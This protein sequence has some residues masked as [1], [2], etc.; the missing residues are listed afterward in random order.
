MK[1]RKIAFRCLVALGLI[2]VSKA[3]T[4]TGDL[5]LVSYQKITSGGRVGWSHAPLNLIAFDR[6]GTGEPGTNLGFFDVYTMNPDGSNQVCLTCGKPG[7]PPYNKGN[8]DWHPSNL[9][10]VISVQ[11]GDRTYSSN[12]NDISN[13]IAQPGRGGD[14]VIYIMDATGTNYWIVP[15]SENGCG[16]LHP[17]FSHDGTKL[18]WAQCLSSQPEDR[19]GTW[20]IQIAS[21]ALPTTDGGAPTV[22]VTQTITPGITPCL[23]E[24]HGFSIDDSTIFFSGTAAGIPQTGNEIYSYN[25]NTGAFADLTNTSTLWDEHA[26]PNPV[27]PKL[28][29]ASQY[30]NQIVQNVFGTDYWSMNYDGSDKKRL[31]WFT[32][33][34]APAYQNGAFVGDNDASPDGMQEIAYLNCQGCGNNQNGNIYLLTWAVST[35]TSS[36]ASYY[37]AP[38]A[39]DSLATTFGTSLDTTA[40]SATTTPLPLQLG[41]TTISI[42]DSTGVTKQA[43]VVYVSPTQINWIVPS[44]LAEGPATMNLTSNGVSHPDTFDIEHVAPAIYT[45]DG[46]GK[47]APAATVNVYPSGGGAPT[48][49]PTYLSSNG[50]VTVAPISVSGGQAYLILYATGIENVQDSVT[51]IIGPN[52]VAGFEGSNV[53]PSSAQ[54][55]QTT[56]AGTQG[57]FQAL[58][59]VNVPLPSS[60]AGAG[61]MYLQL[62]V[63]GY[64]SNTVELNFK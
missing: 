63:D 3:Q 11:R 18:I 26:H 45:A 56:F 64:L 20:E 38:L 12:P 44:G 46:S 35:T 54:T 23:Y 29:W 8:P 52:T 1:Y 22:T 50:T 53:D 41:T 32:D 13:T 37:S 42:T 39:P 25:L 4:P 31:T 21:F 24:T 17:H 48:S 43:P 59:Q 5:T 19:G 33:P 6:Q 40:V 16:V 58:D 15:D 60:L 7:L 47:G 36:N 49:V 10:M 51:A 9:Y 57:Q 27:F 28:I 62:N 34:V 30:E 61:T 2:A 55:I 14:N